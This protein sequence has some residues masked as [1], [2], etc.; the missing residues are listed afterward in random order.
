M[1]TYSI[2]ISLTAANDEN[3]HCITSA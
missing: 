1:T 2:L 3:E